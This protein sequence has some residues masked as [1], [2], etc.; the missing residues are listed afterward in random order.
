MTRDKQNY[1]FKNLSFAFEFIRRT[2]LTFRASEMSAPL[3]VKRDR[4]RESVEPRAMQRTDSQRNDAS[5]EGGSERRDGD[6]S[7]TVGVPGIQ[8]RRPPWPQVAPASPAA[9]RS[10]TF[11]PSRGEILGPWR[12]RASAIH[13]LDPRREK[14]APRRRIRYGT[15]GIQARLWM[16]RAAALQREILEFATRGSFGLFGIHKRR[17]AVQ[18]CKARSSSGMLFGLY[19]FPGERAIGE[20]NSNSGV[21]KLGTIFRDL[22]GTYLGRSFRQRN[23]LGKSKAINSPW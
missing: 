19:V 3:S 10:P 11:A 6:R 18:P 5:N 21:D 7:A 2:R 20:C 23:R 14:A 8:S 12:N 13:G 9:G 22:C 1:V 16:H 15:S 17:E 4:F